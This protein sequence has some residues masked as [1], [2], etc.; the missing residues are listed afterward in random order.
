MPTNP[1]L[2]D[3]CGGDRFLGLGGL[4]AGPP[5]A[6]I[7][8]LATNSSPDLASWARW[9]GVNLGAFAV[10]FPVVAAARVARPLWIPRP[11]AFGVVIAA[12]A[13]IGMTKG[14]GTTLFGSLAGLVPD[15]VG[16]AVGRG[17]NTAVLVRS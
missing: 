11:A 15:P 3:D 6:L 4:L 17:A 2:R 9:A 13:L 16:D 12:G 5:F 7:T 8:S 14:L 1:R 10:T